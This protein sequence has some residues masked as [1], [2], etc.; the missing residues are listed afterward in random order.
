MNANIKYSKDI[1]RYVSR[2]IVEYVLVVVI[3]LK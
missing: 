1:L 2:K 3:F